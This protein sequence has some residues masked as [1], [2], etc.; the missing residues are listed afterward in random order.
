[1]TADGRI[2]AYAARVYAAYYAI[3]GNA[4]RASTESRRAVIEAARSPSLPWDGAIN[5][6]HCGGSGAQGAP[7][8]YCVP[9][10]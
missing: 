2:D 10:E 8:C 1:M 9:C 6:R 4:S 3:D 5:C 7:R